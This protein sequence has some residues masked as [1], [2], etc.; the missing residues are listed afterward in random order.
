M[1]IAAKARPK[2]SKILIQSATKLA[3]LSLYASK[4]ISKVERLEK[5][6]LHQKLQLK[7]SKMQLRYGNPL[8]K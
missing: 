7:I 5:G 1:S 3:K 8:A 6:H 2:T 4:T